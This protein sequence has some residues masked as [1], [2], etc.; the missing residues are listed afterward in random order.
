MRELRYQRYIRDPEGE[1]TS[2]YTSEKSLKDIF[3]YHK[4]GKVYKIDKDTWLVIEK[5]QVLIY[6]RPKD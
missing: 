3:E 2:G 5:E 1:S 4:I 6:R